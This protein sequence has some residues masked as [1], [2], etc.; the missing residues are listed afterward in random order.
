MRTLTWPDTSWSLFDDLYGLRDEMNRVFDRSGF[1]SERFP[2]VNAWVNDEKIVMEFELPG[3]NAE[4]VDISVK[5]ETVSI[6]GERKADELKEGE[7]YHRQERAQGSF[8]R[9]LK[10]PFRVESESAEANYE[11]GVLRLTLERSEEDK[12]KKIKIKAE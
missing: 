12:P 1:Y 6:S 4:N 7:S 11:K 3:V 5:G 10:L 9:I 8:N 2:P